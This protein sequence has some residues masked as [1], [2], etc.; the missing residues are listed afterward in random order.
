MAF[1]VYMLECA[2]GSIYTGHSDDLEARLA[3]HQAGT[4][5]GYT[6]GRRPVRLIYCDTTETRDEAFAMERRIKGWSRAKKLALAGGDWKEIVR[7]ARE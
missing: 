6:H 2:D 5:P 7:L 1:Y 3:A 4:F